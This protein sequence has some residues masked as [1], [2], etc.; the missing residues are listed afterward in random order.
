[1]LFNT[2]YLLR[3]TVDHDAQENVVLIGEY[4]EM[5]SCVGFNPTCLNP[6]TFLCNAFAFA[7]CLL[8]PH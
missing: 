3:W 1:M 4:V 7:L 8:T 2:N 5:L 6:A